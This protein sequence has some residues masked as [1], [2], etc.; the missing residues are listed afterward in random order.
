MQIQRIETDNLHYQTRFTTI[1]SRTW[2]SEPA[3]NTVLRAI[4]HRSF[5]RVCVIRPRSR[6]LACIQ[7]IMSTRR[8][9][10]APPVQAPPTPSRGTRGSRVKYQAEDAPDEDGPDGARSPNHGDGAGATEDDGDDDAD[11]QSDLTPEPGPSQRGRRGRARGRAR[12]SRNVVRLSRKQEEP[13][14]GDDDDENVLKGRRVRKSV[15]YREVPVDEALEAEADEED[16]ARAN[17]EE[18]AEGE[19]GDGEGDGEEEEDADA[20]ADDPGQCKLLTP[21]PASM[22]SDMC[23]ADSTDATTPRRRRNRPVDD[24][25]RVGSGRGGFSV[26]GAAAAAARARW[27]KHRAEKAERGEDSDDGVRR[28]RRSAARGQ[29]TSSKAAQD[30]YTKGAKIEVKGVEYVVGNDE[31]ELPDDEKGETKVDKEGRLLGGEFVDLRTLCDQ[32]SSRSCMVTRY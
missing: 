5:I 6:L 28:P 11:G 20:D 25:E 21:Q 8:S 29:Q 9:A 18:D 17:E 2:G 22:M 13:E 26:K 14:A 15:S 31:L 12:G 4:L 7:S 10:R 19:E 3:G 30:T 32:M 16:E 1:R 23:R 27:A 24:R